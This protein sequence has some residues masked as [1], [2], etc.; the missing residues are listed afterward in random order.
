[1]TRTDGLKELT[2]VLLAAGGS[3]RMG[4]PKQLLQ[5]EG[6]SLVA[7]MTL[8]LMALELSSVMVVTGSDSQAVSDQLSGLPIQIVHN[9]CWEEGMASSLAA[10]VE[11]LPEES[12][13]VLILLC[14]QWQ[15]GLADLQNLVHIWSTDI[16][17]ITAAAWHEK[18]RHVIGPPV[19]F[20]RTLFEELTSLKGDRGARA[21]IEKHRER[22]S[23]V[24]MESACFDLDEPVDLVRGL[25]PGN[26]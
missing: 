17:Q 11:N 24:A 26:Q 14:D 23:F 10:G 22:A 1:M 3:S 5:I 8:R 12:E 21:V 7:R 18:E 13:G 9:P 25:D 6:E 15:V 4:Q 19:I 2:A 16:S 20:P